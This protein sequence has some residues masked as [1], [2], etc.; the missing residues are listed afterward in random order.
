MPEHDL[1]TKAGDFAYCY[2]N[3]GGRKWTSEIE[4]KDWLFWAKYWAVELQGNF[5]GGLKLWKIKEIRM[6]KVWR[7]FIV[8]QINLMSD[9]YYV[10]FF[11]NWTMP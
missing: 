4:L 8:I 10:T 1:G 6:N 2:E 5:Y 3:V 7:I 11:K 9:K